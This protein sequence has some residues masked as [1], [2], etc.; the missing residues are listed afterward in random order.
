MTPRKSST[1]STTVNIRAICSIVNEEDAV[2]A[3]PPCKIETL[4]RMAGRIGVSTWMLMIPTTSSASFF[5][6]PGFIVKVDGM[7]WVC[8]EVHWGWVVAHSGFG[9]SQSHKKIDNNIQAVEAQINDIIKA[10]V[11]EQLDPKLYEEGTTDF[12][13]L[14][15]NTKF[16]KI[17]L[18]GTVSI[19][20]RE[21]CVVS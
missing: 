10:K 5:F 6:G 16:V 17:Q 4:K 20:K 3:F 14:M 9:K 18:D 21:G 19:L 7:D 15:A 13:E 2:Q 1:K 11:L 8:G 12:E